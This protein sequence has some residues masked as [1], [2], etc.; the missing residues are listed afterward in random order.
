MNNNLICS[1]GK[2]SFDKK[3][4]TSFKNLTMKLHHIK[5][6]EYE[7]PE[8]GN[9]HLGTIQKNKRGKFKHIADNE[10]MI[11]KKKMWRA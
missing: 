6:G 11:L 4:A 8:C 9:W 5:M 1:S 10:M 3:G 7:C 2:R